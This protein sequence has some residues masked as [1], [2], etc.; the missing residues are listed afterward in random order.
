M[1]TSARIEQV[2]KPQGMDWVSS[3]RAPQIAQLAAERGPFQPSLFDQR[4]LMET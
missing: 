1:L 3:L 4:N 2:L